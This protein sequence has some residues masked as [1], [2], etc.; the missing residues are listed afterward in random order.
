[1]SHR[2]VRARTLG[3]IIFT[4]TL[5]P[6][7]G[8]YFQSTVLEGVIGHNLDGVWWVEHRVMPEFRVRLDREAL[9]IPFEAGAISKELQD[10][11]GEFVHGVVVAKVSDQ[12]VAHNHGIFEGDIITRVNLDKL[13]ADGM[14]SYQAALDKGTPELLLTV[15]RPK[16]RH[17]YVDIV[18]IR[19]VP[20]VAE[21]DGQS[22]VVEETL[23]W[24]YL[25]LQLP[26]ESDLDKARSKGEAWTIPAP[27]FNDL[28]ENWW[29]LDDRNPALFV[30][31]EHRVVS[32]DEYDSSLRLDDNVN[33][34]LF[35]MVTVKNTNPMSGASGQQISGY[36]FREV[37][38]D[39]IGGTY[40]QATL[41][42]A[43]FPISLEFKGVFQMRKLADYSD[44][45]AAR[46]AKIQQD[47]AVEDQSKVELAPDI[48]EDLE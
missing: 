30:K 21:V 26:F 12:S 17:T 3:A 35:A 46:K 47:I 45:D 34:A 41:A 44:K 8:A 13:T 20:K 9:G 39:E 33:D 10:S 22:R 2:L 27:A 43:P 24:T 14:K 18:K 4:L 16:L 36:G 37:G 6:A 1:M 25:D 29:K 28:K 7:A 5:A 48:P 31:G 38:T 40:V 11:I 15:R 19:Y 32:N 23:R 42:N